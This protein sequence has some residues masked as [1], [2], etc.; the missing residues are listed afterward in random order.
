MNIKI[1]LLAIL[2]LLAGCSTSKSTNYD[3]SDNRK[4]M[5]EERTTDDD[6][7]YLLDS[8][9][10][11]NNIKL[12]SYIEDNR[13]KEFCKTNYNIDDIYSTYTILN[14][15]RD[16]CNQAKKTEKLNEREYILI[17]DILSTVAFYKNL[18]NDF[19]IYIIL[20]L[21]IIISSLAYLFIRIY[22]QFFKY[23]YYTKRN[24]EL[25]YKNNKLENKIELQQLALIKNDELLYNIDILQNKH[26]AL[27]VH[28]RNI[29]SYL[30]NEK[31]VIK[32]S[33][34]QQ[35][36]QATEKFK[37]ECKNSYDL[38][39]NINLEKEELKIE[40]LK[41]S[42]NIDQVIKNPENID[43][44]YKLRKKLKKLISLLN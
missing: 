40:I 15:H 13:I 42:K 41:T 35:F 30:E 24:I 29:E 20:I 14:H 38:N 8:I 18:F 26:K 44:I 33:Y 1:I 34:R 43:Q 4:S 28:C 3:I 31:K 16:L 36:K 6:K 2:I 11:N 39:Q 21:I 10:S 32:K 23:K 25:K 9:L 12:N 5:L 17:I 7:K 37:K 19:E 22:E 27:T